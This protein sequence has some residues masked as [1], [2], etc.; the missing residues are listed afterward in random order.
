MSAAHPIFERLF[1]DMASV[2]LLPPPVI[3]LK[4]E[5]VRREREAAEQRHAARHAEPPEAA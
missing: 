2:G 5:R 4:A 3:D 1:A